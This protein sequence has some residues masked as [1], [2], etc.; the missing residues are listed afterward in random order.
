[1]Q[2]FPMKVLYFILGL[3]VAGGTVA[4]GTG[5][6]DR[7]L[8]D[9][10]KLADGPRADEKGDR[11]EAKPAPIAAIPVEPAPASPLPGTV[12]APET[13]AAAAPVPG[14]VIVPRFDLVRV[15]PDGSLLVAG[16]AA[17]EASVEVVTG[18]RVLATAVSDRTGDF[19]AVLEDRLAP[20]DYQ[21]VLRS[22]TADNVVATSLETAV[23]SIPDS[24][25]GQVLAIVEQ[26][27]APARLITV[28]EPAAPAPEA[29]EAPAQAQDTPPA[30]AP[31][32]PAAAPE[33]PVATPE[34]PVAAAE[35]PAAPS[36]T[37]APAEPP[38]AAQSPEPAPSE[39]E[40]A[41]RPETPA[42]PDVASAPPLAPPPSSP[43]PPARQEPAVRAR[44]AVEAVEIEG[45]KIFVAGVAEAERYVRVY[46]NEIFLGEVQASPGGRFLVETERELAVGDYIIRADLLGADRSTVIARAA[47]PFEREA[48]E[49][50][51]AVAPAAPA[52]TPEAAPAP[53]PAAT[54]PA[55][56][57]AAAPEAPDA[58]AKEP[59]A[60]A[61]QTPEPPASAPGQAA[62][63]PPVSS[64]PPAAA[65]EATPPPAS[66]PAT[67]AA[68]PQSPPATPAEPD[69]VVAPKLERADSAV[70]IRRG[71]TLWR[72]SRR[73]Y[74][75][76]IRYSTI[77][78]ANQDQI[79]DP[80]RIWPGQIFAMP[81]ETA[82]GAK[83][84]WDALGNQ[85]TE[86]PKP[87]VN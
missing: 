9:E 19:V 82:D 2:A 73:V 77:Y 34:A 48:G 8:A 36:E 40:T 58:P 79:E 47:V 6:F 29:P 54:A 17:P 33:A 4:Y 60:A 21:I 27:G 83:A 51:A 59:E 57:A 72:I 22:T 11:V 64:P 35:E 18:T 15:E 74:G 41:S 86:K 67:A 1:M 24:K 68:E 80:D 46:A 3:A 69:V 43:Q 32:A 16:T 78:L 56:P 53:A 75:Q 49:N 85:L 62:A 66:P 38:V 30:A 63:T 65:V 13:P 5:W 50:I 39:P 28:P 14:D 61:Q 84:N 44:I 87:E 70:I 12:P 71:D 31:E 76:G 37:P 42:A 10:P 25:D 23:V 55:A 20:G 52:E 7:F 81:D 45:R 26:P